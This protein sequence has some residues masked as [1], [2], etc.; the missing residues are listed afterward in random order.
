MDH[1]LKENVGMEPGRGREKHCMKNNNNNNK[2]LAFEE[3]Q[4]ERPIYGKAY[5][6]ELKAMKSMFTCRFGHEGERDLNW[7]DFWF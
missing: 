4:K 6:T 5:R 3:K 7:M 1:D 2:T